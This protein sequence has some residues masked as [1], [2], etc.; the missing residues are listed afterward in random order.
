LNCEFN[1]MFYI[2]TPSA[3]FGPHGFRSPRCGMFP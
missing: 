1:S 3:S 2:F